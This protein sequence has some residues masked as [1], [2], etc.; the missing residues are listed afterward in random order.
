VADRYRREPDRFSTQL[1]FYDALEREWR[2]VG[3]FSPQGSGAP[4]ITIYQNSDPDDSAAGSVLPD[5]LFQ[6]LQGQFVEVVDGFLAKLAAALE[7]DLHDVAAAHVYSH[8]GML[9]PHRLGWAQARMGRLAYEHGN[10]GAAAK[11]FKQSLEAGLEDAGWVYVSL[12]AAHAQLGDLEAAI[13]V[14]GRGLEQG[15]KDPNLYWNTTEAL[16]SRH[17]LGEAEALC[18]RAMGQGVGGADPYLK[19][20]H[21]KGLLEDSAAAAAVLADGIRVN[22]GAPR[23]HIAVGDL[24]A[25]KQDIEGAAASYREALRISPQSADALSRLRSLEAAH[26]R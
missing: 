25:A 24:Q 17:R 10:F 4:A 8:T 22:P 21:I 11:Y 6:G 13:L 3:R 14:W 5:S 15:L 26:G 16:I 1:A 2:R 20:A 23:L 9:V 19:L 18:R 12:G 7:T